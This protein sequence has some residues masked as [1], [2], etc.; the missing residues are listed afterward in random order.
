M[1]TAVTCALFTLNQDCIK[2]SCIQFRSDRHA[3]IQGTSV[4]KQSLNNIQASEKHQ[5]VTIAFCNFVEQ[6]LYNFRKNNHENF[7][8]SLAVMIIDGVHDLGVDLPTVSDEFF[9]R[10]ITLVI[11][12]FQTPIFDFWNLYR[13]SARNTGGEYYLIS[14]MFDILAQ[15]ILLTLSGGYTLHQAFTHT[16]TENS[17]LDINNATNIV[18]NI[19]QVILSTIQFLIT[20]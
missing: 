16:H 17:L 9:R 10:D 20:G 13:V 19:K 5:T 14:N 1:T 11:A 12:A 3:P 4:I 8:E 18:G 6:Q 15:I 2:L 7:H